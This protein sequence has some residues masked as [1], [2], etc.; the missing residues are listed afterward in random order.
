MEKH[1]KVKVKQK[2]KSTL[3]LVDQDEEVQ[4][5]P[6]PQSKGDDTDLELAL[7]LSLDEFQG[8]DLYKPKRRSISDQYILQRRIPIAEEE[9]TG[10]SIQLQDDTIDQTIHDTS[11]L[12]DSINVQEKTV[13][14]EKTDNGSGTEILK[15][16]EEQ[17][18]AVSQTVGLE[19]M[20]SKLD[21]GQ[22]GSDPGRTPE[23]K[24]PPEHKQMDKEQA[25]PDPGQSHV[26]LVGSNPKHMHED[27]TFIIYPKVHE[28]MKFLA[29]EEIILEDPHSSSGTLS[30]IKNLDDAFNFGDQFVNDK[31]TED[32]PGKSNAEAKVSPPPLHEQYLV[33]T[34]DTTTTTLP[35]PPPPPLQQS[36]PSAE[37]LSY[38]STLEQLCA[39]LKK[40]HN[41]H[42][43]T[44]QAI[45]SRVFNLELRDLPH[46]IN[47]TVN[48]AVK[49]AVK[50]ALQALLRRSSVK[51]RESLTSDVV[52]TNILLYHQQR[53]PIKAKDQ[54]TILMHLKSVIHSEQPV[55]EV[56]IPEEVHHSDSEDTGM[57]HIPKINPKP[58]WLKPVPKEDRPETP[59]PDWVI[60]SNDLPELENNWANAHANSYQDPDENKLI[61]KTGDMNLFIK[62][63][64]RHIGKPKLSKADLEGPAYKVVRAFYSNSIS[65]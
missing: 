26:A 20:T 22:A 5:D 13:D 55:Y 65:L 30:L 54:D 21:E 29:D 49:E 7:Q 63:Y 3:K 41:L 4:P 44:T 9:T 24:P 42:K 8:Q 45:S 43:Q 39:N 46:K 25:G 64:C 14:S 36:A 51:L 23:S 37:M 56:P 47:E 16:D 33:A 11:S 32:E 50:V 62:W 59:E 60:P 57:T 27:F 2:R 40:Q 31:S 61:Q 52:K 35:F 48:E 34:A 10:P 58:D 53:I 17:G 1:G 28:S 6:I 18:E 38:I 19:E 15:L 12:A